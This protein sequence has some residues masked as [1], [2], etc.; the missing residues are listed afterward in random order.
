MTANIN[1]NALASEYAS[2]H[3]SRQNQVCHMIGIPLILLALVKLTQWPTI[4]PWI[5]LALPVYFFWSLRLGIAMTCVVAVMALFSYLFLN[6]WSAVGIF[7][8]GW[9]FQLVGHYKFEKNRPSFAH[10]LI[11]LFIGPAWIIQK[12]AKEGF[13]ISLW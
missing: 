5:A 11:H 8:V 2:E 3:Q 6:V 7:L 9:I 13:G 4:F 12:I 10:N 1:W